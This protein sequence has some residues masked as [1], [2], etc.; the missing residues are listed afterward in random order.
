MIN[1]IKFAEK[2]SRM[3]RLIPYN[4]FKKLFETADLKVSEEQYRL[5][6]RYAE[7]LCETNEKINLTAITSPE[8]IAEK[9]FLDSVLALKYADFP[10]G[11]ELADVGTGAGFPGV[12]LKIFRP[13]LKLT[14]ID[15]LQK[16]VRFLE[17]LTRAL[18]IEAACLHARAEDLGKREF[19]GRFDV[20]TARAVSRLSKLAGYCLPLLKR[21][22]V[23]V[24]LKGVDCADEI[25]EA[26][27]VLKRYG[28]VVLGVKEYRLPSGDGRTV[29]RVGRGE[30]AP[31]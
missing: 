8:G 15:S 18:G 12:P 13:D 23:L 21:G 29:V 16:R 3:E 26:E 4:D 27:A 31:K 25:D 7:M 14:L 6:S 24:A 5:F 20:V 2:V 10:F 22:G 28:G 17:E 11:A 1:I 30:S 19:S 9:H